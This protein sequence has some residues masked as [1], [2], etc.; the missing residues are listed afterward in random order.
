[1]TKK[2]LFVLAGFLA[3]AFSVGG[4]IL[5]SQDNPKLRWRR[6]LIQFKVAGVMPGEDWARLVRRIGPSSIKFEGVQLDAARVSRSAKTSGERL[7]QRRC[8]ICHGKDGKGG[9]EGGHVPVD[10]SRRD[11]QTSL[12]DLDIYLTL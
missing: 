4:F 5:L 11:F 6:E 12:S 9:G 8:S 2:K 1:M 7:F 10:F 3:M